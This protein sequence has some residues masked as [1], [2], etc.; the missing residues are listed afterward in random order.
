MADL[1]SKLRHLGRPERH[2]SSPGDSLPGATS[3]SFV[4]EALS[5][6]MTALIHGDESPQVRPKPPISCEPPF[7]ERFID[8]M[9]VGVRE[10]L[11]GGREGVGRIP[12][13]SAKV[14]SPIILGLVGL[15]PHLAALHTD[16]ALYLDTE[17]TGLGAGAGT[18][19]FLVGM[20][21]FEQGVLHLQ[22]LFL[23]TPAEEPAMLSIVE[24]RLREA[25]FLVT[26][27]GK[28]FDWPLLVSRFVMN[29]RAPP[30]CPPHLDLLH[31]ARRL[32]KARLG[33]VTLR[34]LEGEVLGMVR[35]PDVDGAEI[36]PRYAHFLRTGDGSNL[37]I[38]VEHNEHD[39]LSMVALVGLYGEPVPLLPEGDLV[40]L[41]RT[42]VRAGD[43]RRA[44]L[45]VDG[46]VNSGGGHDARKLAAELARAR[47]DRLRALA[48]FEALVKDVDDPGIRL[49]LAK[50]YEH[51]CKSPN[52]A[53][54]MVEEGTGEKPEA[55]RRRRARLLRKLSRS[56]PSKP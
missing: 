36:G 1:K 19:A 27:N 45:L 9:A 7:V 24:A 55:M 35:G 3:R 39:V 13:D 41:A 2:V 43:R 33:S 10:H 50:L 40:A 52:L 44:E 29:H 42:Y 21:W 4:I 11:V 31:V 54:F 12:L 30:P 38:V 17:T 49:S 16:K 47:G 51:F 23:R 8:G 15:S 22:Q 28:S 20:A 25:E 34:R 53:L 32:H 46:V 26:F 56:S 48:D 37:K 18:L 6:E 5:R 14:A